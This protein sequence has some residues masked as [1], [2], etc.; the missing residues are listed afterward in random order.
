MWRRHHGGLNPPR[1]GW[2]VVKGAVFWVYER[3]DVLLD[4]PALSASCCDRYRGAGFAGARCCP[5]FPSAIATAGLGLLAPVVAR[6]FLLQSL[7]RVWLGIIFFIFIDP[8]AGR[9]L[10]SLLRQSKQRKALHPTPAS[11]STSQAFPLVVRRFLC[12]SISSRCLNTTGSPT[13]RH[14]CPKAC[15]RVTLKPNDCSPRT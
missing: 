2:G 12:Y 4:L 10:L 7:P 13:L 1:R 8:C 3:F 5:L 6:C 15:L 14:Q 9:H 11:V